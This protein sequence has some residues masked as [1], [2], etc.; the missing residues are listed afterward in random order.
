M[1]T[2]S[3][4]LK[5]PRWQRK[6]L[7]IFERDNWSC[8][9]C[10]DISTTLHIHHKEYIKN[11]EP[12]EYNDEYLETL[13]AVCHSQEH[14]LIVI[15]ERKHEHLLLR[16]FEDSTLTSIQTHIDILMN[17][18]SKGVPKELEAEILKNII[19]LQ[20]KKREHLNG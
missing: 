12:W 6:R 4:K 13:C 15:P 8:V 7:E 3:E 10:G 9:Q 2:Y 5:D 14:E 11:R 20:G 19:Y 1:K 17:K 18:L 16:Q